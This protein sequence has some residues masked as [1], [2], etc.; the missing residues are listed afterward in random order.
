LKETQQQHTEG[1]HHKTIVK[2][3]DISTII[4]SP[5]IDEQGTLPSL[6]VLKN[7]RTQQQARASLSSTSSST[8]SSPIGS[9]SN[10]G[11]KRLHVTNLPFK[12]RDNELRN[13]FAVCVPSND[14]LTQENGLLNNL[15]FL[16]ASWS[17]FVRVY[18]KVLN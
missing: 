10:D 12:V 8:T 17:I 5:Q 6:Q 4:T 7:S 1:K 13:M 14:L 16:L 2:N 3:A 9:L 15:N 11:P 18:A